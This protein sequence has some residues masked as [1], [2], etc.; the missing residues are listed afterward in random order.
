M[1]LNENYESATATNLWYS[2]TYKVR[3]TTLVWKNCY[4]AGNPSLYKFSYKVWNLDG[5]ELR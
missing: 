3:G 1:W 4:A 5:L 2:L